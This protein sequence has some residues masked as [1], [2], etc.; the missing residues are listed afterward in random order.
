[1]RLETLLVQSRKILDEF[2]MS[3]FKLYMRANSYDP[4]GIMTKRVHKYDSSW[5][6]MRV[7][8]VGMTLDEKPKKFEEPLDR[9]NRRTGELED[10]VQ[11]ENQMILITARTS[12]DLDDDNDENFQY[13]MPPHQSNRVKDAMDRISERDRIINDLEKKVGESA[14]QRDYYQREAES[15]GG[16]IR[17]LK[18]K[19]SH[20]SERLADSE[21]Q[22][23]HYRTLVKQDHSSSLEHEGFMDE[24]MNTARNRGAF[25]AKDSADVITDAA[26]RQKTA[27]Q[28]MTG[29]GA[30]MMSPEF[31]TKA[32]VANIERRILETVRNVLETK[33]RVSPQEP[34][35]ETPPRS[36]EILKMKKD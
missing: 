10:I 25:E 12:E 11:M 28:Q 27:Q 13:L 6:S 23:Y 32:D 30:G 1:M 20:I 24:K 18:A 31:A 35:S 3:P 26:K 14:Q 8:A 34:K 9:K 17:M 4:V 16:E 7:W 29:L 21:Q 15:A 33:P 36:D 2:R 22:A 5:G 19:V